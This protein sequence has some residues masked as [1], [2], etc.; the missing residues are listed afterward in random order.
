MKQEP[1]EITIMVMRA[2]RM[3]GEPIEEGA[4]VT[5]DRALAVQLISAGKAEQVAAVAREKLAKPDL[6]VSQP[7]QIKR[8]RK[9]HGA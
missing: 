3:A 6:L 2:I 1:K 9:P 4:I 7:K 5:V 8:G